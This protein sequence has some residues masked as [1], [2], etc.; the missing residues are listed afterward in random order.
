MGRGRKKIKKKIDVLTKS[1]CLSHLGG[2]PIKIFDVNNKNVIIFNN[3]SLVVKELNISLRKTVGRWIVDG[4]IHH[5][6]SSKYPKVRLSI[7]IFLSL[8]RRKYLP[9]PPYAMLCYAN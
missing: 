5:T 6:L 8:E 1:K 3:K 2:V 9:T 7:Y 4:L